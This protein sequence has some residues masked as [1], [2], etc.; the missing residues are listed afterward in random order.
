MS[1]TIDGAPPPTE[2]LIPEARRHQRARYRRSAFFAALAALLI[3]ALV[4]LAVAAP[5]NSSGPARPTGAPRAAAAPASATVLVRPVLCLAPQ[6]TAA[7][8][9]PGPLPSSCPAPYGNTTAADGVSPDV[10]V[11][12]GY[13]ESPQRIDPGLARY[14]STV[15]DAPH[16]VV[17]LGQWGDR[18]GARYL[19]GPASMRLSKAMV[20]SAR[21][22][23]GATG[24]WVVAI[25][26]TPA[27]SVAWDAL[28]H[29]YFHAYL[30]V[31]LHGAVVTAPLIQPTARSFRSFDG[32]MQVS[33]GLVTAR[34]AHE[35]TA[36][37]RG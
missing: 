32:S 6:A 35:L 18:N 26:F 13:T 20:R 1:R 5:W 29:R 21:S 34:A 27:G 12:N 31:D 33:G 23:R 24:A 8:T 36:A 28:A 2:V 11:P 7:S 9:V 16:G 25:Q 4:A 37:I 14:A 10:D 19:L 17:L 30:A 3:G 15:R 22:E